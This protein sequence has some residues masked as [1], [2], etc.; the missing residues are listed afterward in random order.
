MNKKETFTKAIKANE[1]LIY[2][3]ASMYT[4]TIHDRND[5]VQEII[6]NLWKSFDTFN[7]KSSL[8]TWMYKVAMN[9]AIYQLKT[10]KRKV[11]TVPLEGQCLNFH[12]SESSDFEEKLQVFKQH[13]GY[14]NLLDKGIVMLYLENKS[15][16]EIADIVGLSESNVGTKIARIKEKLKKQIAK[17]YNYGTG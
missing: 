9:V 16:Q 4:D 12:E 3:M 8:S 15:Y 14:L 5:L 2:K 6:Y 1:G 17:K 11:E 13:L 7:Q 10:A